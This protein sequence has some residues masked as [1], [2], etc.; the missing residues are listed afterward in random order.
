LHH[1]FGHLITPIRPAG[2]D[3][4][5]YGAPPFG[6]KSP[7]R[8][9]PAIMTSL[10]A[11]LI[12]AC[13]VTNAAATPLTPFRNEAQAKRYCPDDTVVWLDLGKGLYYLK[14]QKRYARGDTGSF[15]C[16]GEARS[17]GYRRSFLGIR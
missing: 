11:A 10:L 13:C 5:Q 17:G 16:R 9:I 3:L 15:V 6:T 1:L 8:I 14:G 4:D 12:M 7:M 2:F